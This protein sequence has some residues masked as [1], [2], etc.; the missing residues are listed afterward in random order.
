LAERDVFSTIEDLEDIE[1]VGDDDNDALVV[2]GRFG[3]AWLLVPLQAG[4]TGQVWV[5]TLEDREGDALVV[6]KRQR[7]SLQTDIG[8]ILQNVARLRGQQPENVV[9]VVDAGVADGFGW[10]ATSYIEGADLHVLQSRAKDTG[11]PLSAGVALAIAVGVLDGLVALH[12]LALV[13]R[14]LGP[15]NIV[16]GTDGSVTV[17]D[18]D[19]VVPVGTAATDTVP[20]NVS[21]MSPEQAQGLP[22]DGRADL[23][24]WAIVACEIFSGDTFYGDLSIADVW[25]LTRTGGYRPRRFTDI[26]LAVRGVLERCL[27]GDPADRFLT[28]S[29]CREALLAAAAVD[30]IVMADR[31][32]VAAAVM[33]LVGE[34][35]V[36]QRERLQEA[37]T[38]PRAARPVPPLSMSA[39]KTPPSSSASSPSAPP[40]PPVIASLLRGTLELRPGADMSSSASLSSSLSSTSASLFGSS[41]SE[42]SASVMRPRSRHG[43]A[44]AAVVVA[45]LALLVLAVI[46]GGVATP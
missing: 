41:T 30:G 29:S 36:R 15:A 16:V 40:A 33:G 34:R 2:P 5:A 42:Q 12:G 35:I 32:T 26:P 22:V 31:S 18:V 27:R 37:R 24:A 3:P 21:Y 20:G 1:T 10:V 44:V 39:P 7:P 8:D 14:D 25:S 9:V 38:M 28:A 17:V 45:L 11:Q 23:L 43:V 46:S 13:H 6:F 4:A 19:F